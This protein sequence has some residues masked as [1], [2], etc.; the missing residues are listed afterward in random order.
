MNSILDKIAVIKIIPVVVIDDENSA[1]PLASALME[2]GL[3]CAEVTFRTNAAKNAIAKM[4]KST[5]DMLIGAGTV[6]TVN[7][8]KS[9]VDAGAQFIVSPGISRS[10][11][12]YCLNNAI[13]V[14]PGVVTPTEIG[15]AL[16]MGLATVKFF[17]AE[18]SGGIQYLKAVSAPFGG[19]KFIPTGGI[20]ETNVSTYLNFPKVTACGGSWMVKQELIKNGRFDEISAITKRAV[21]LVEGL[22]NSN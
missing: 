13:P 1:V 16:E 14:F 2:A 18:E 11:V 17:P 10:V 5:S 22:K 8:A 19:M 21:S 4:S 3:P 20:N 9:A 7:Q 6:L 12:E 15:L